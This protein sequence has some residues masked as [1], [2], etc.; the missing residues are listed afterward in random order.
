M[1]VC[2]RVQVHDMGVSERT[3]FELIIDDISPPY[4]AEEVRPAA[5]LPLHARLFRQQSCLNLR[6]PI[7]PNLSCVIEQVVCDR[8]GRFDCSS[9]MWLVPP[10]LI[11]ESS[12]MRRAAGS[13][14]TPATIAVSHV[15]VILFW[16]SIRLRW[17]T[18]I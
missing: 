16:Q 1:H 9:S 15:A 7:L 2:P 11:S 18:R 4:S 3:E 17:R 14:T 12:A 10:D 8:F 6:N 5:A 13:V